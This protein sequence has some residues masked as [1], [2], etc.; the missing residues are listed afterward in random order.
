MLNDNNKYDKGVELF[1]IV[2]C[3]CY[4]DF[5]YRLWRQPT[6]YSASEYWMF[7]FLSYPMT[8]WSCSYRFH[9]R[10]CCIWHMFYIQYAI[11]IMQ[12]V[13][14]CLIYLNHSYILV[15]MY[16]FY[17]VCPNC[18]W[19]V[20]CFLA[21]CTITLKLELVTLDKTSMIMILKENNQRTPL[22]MRWAMRTASFNKYMHN[23]VK[24]HNQIKQP[25]Q[26]QLAVWISPLALQSLLT[27]VA[28]CLVLLG[29][30]C[31]SPPWAL[32]W[33]QNIRFVNKTS[34]HLTSR[35]KR[36]L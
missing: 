33:G 25:S 6:L 34:P 21:T 22:P 5:V 18:Y 2:P 23:S 7:V 17:A 1:I 26:T 3:S 36:E 12:D 30:C 24:C 35:L 20:C 16:F 32:L 28:V 29:L 15:V 9:T 11:Y 4:E 19:F 27:A 8:S 13:L 10:S 14:Y 31:L